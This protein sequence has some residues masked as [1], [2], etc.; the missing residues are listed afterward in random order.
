MALGRGYGQRDGR[1][2]A[3]V[4]AGRVLPL[5]AGN[6]L[7]ALPLDG[8]W[9]GGEVLLVLLKEAANCRILRRRVQLGLEARRRQPQRR[10]A[11]HRLQPPG[12]GLQPLQRLLHLAQ[13]QAVVRPR[14]RDGLLPGLLDPAP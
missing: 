7:A 9:L 13:R 11:L 6:W 1:G 10:L 4:H 5:G 12:D 2:A 14:R 8:E 3:M